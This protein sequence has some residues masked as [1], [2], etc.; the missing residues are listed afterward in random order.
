ME[1]QHPSAEKVKP[2]SFVEKLTNVFASPGELFEN[3]RLTEKTTSN[4]AVPMIIMIVVVIAMGQ[5]IVH[6]ASLADQ[7]G[8]TIKK[9]FDK[10]VQEGKMPQE[11]ADQAYEQFARPGST[12]FTIF[13]IGAIVIGTPIFLF[14]LGL[15]Y[16]L[17]GKWGLKASAPY[18]KVVEVVGLTFFIAVLGSIVTTL[19]MVAMDSIYASPG[20]GAFVSNFSMENKLH[21][22]LAKVNVFTIWSLVVV[23]SGLAKL[24]QRD[25]A[26]VLVLILVL[27]V[28][29]F[30]LTIAL[31]INLGM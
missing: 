27:W 25:Y 24:F 1:E 28:L 14:L 5:I 18:M 6:N 12:M 31:G 9:G 4:W 2:M 20:L 16:W 11:R 22:A 13:Q 19:M 15:V 3:V 26:K 8:E 30:A 21:L 10:Q 23:S 17:L 7:L 29:W